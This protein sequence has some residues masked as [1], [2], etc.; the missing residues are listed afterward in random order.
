MYATSGQEFEYAKARH[1]S[2][3][4]ALIRGD[5]P[6]ALTYLDEARN[7]YDA[8]GETNPDLA[9]DRC[10]ALLAAG[11]A[12]EAAQ[13]TDGRA[14]PTAS[15]G[16]DSVQ[17]GGAALRGRH[18]RPGRRPPGRRQRAC[19]PGPPAVPHAGSAPLGGARR[20]R[21]RRG[22]VRRGRAFHGLA[23]VRRAGRRP[24]RRGPG[25]RG[26]AGAPARRAHRA[27]PGERD[28]RP[29]RTSSTPR[30]PAAAGRRCPGA[31]PGWPGPCRPTRRATPGPP[32][33]LAPVGS[34]PSRSTRCGS[35]PPSCART[36]RRTAP[37][38]PRWPSATRFVVATSAGCCSGASGGGRPRWPPGAHRSVDDKELAA[39]LRSPAQRQPASRGYRDGRPAPEC[40]GARAAAARGGRPGPHAQVARPPGTRGRPVQPGRALRRARPGHADRARHGGRHLARGRRRG[41]PGP[42]AHGGQR[43]RTRGPAEPLRAA[44]PRPWPPAT[45]RRNRAEVQ[46]RRA[47]G[48]AARRRGRRARGRPGRGDPARP[49]PGGAMDPHAVV[50]R[51]RRD[52][53]AVR[54]GL[55]A[56]PS[57]AAA[58]PA[59]RRPRHRA[60]AGH[61]GCG[62]RAAGVSLSRSHAAGSRQRHGRPGAHR[63]GRRVAGA[64]RGSRHVPGR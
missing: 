47:G 43:A 45:R 61:Q 18:R 60:R 40:P 23:P 36:A 33:R 25:R 31:W 7:R 1:N 21:P 19:T 22:Q 15:G 13:E 30:G 62:D 44:P 56:C 3:C 58:I 57:H 32:S 48:R 20:P 8:L 49:V 29:T 17:E 59:A 6:E 52:R 55:A 63:P 54:V 14:Q 39:E 5:L 53:G 42:P 10:S 27:E 34:T 2:G 24:S 64:H 38:S 35:A 26:D 16:R 9:V 41:P 51:S 50:A 28:H 11:L 37:S 12:E 4:V 46:G